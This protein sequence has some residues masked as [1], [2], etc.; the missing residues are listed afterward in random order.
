MAQHF[1]RFCTFTERLELEAVIPACTRL[2][3][4]DL[5]FAVPI[6]L[7]RDAG[8]VIIDEAWH[9]ECADEVAG[10][11]QQQIGVVP[12]QQRKPAFLHVLRIIKGSLPEQHHW[13]V[14][15]VFTEVSETLIS[16]S[17][18]RVPRDEQVLATIREVLEE[19]RREETEPLDPGPDDGGHVATAEP[20]GSRRGGAVVRDLYRGLPAARHPGGTGRAGVVGFTAGDAKRIV[21]E[22]HGKAILSQDLWQS[23]T[24]TVRFMRQHGLLEHAATQETLEM[25]RLVVPGAKRS[26]S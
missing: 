26:R 13:L 23:A 24:P 15:L 11:V 18:N 3:F 14:D 25:M 5:P 6:A 8:R 4:G 9:A 1:Y 10:R 2:R 19:H 20:G 22:T 7:S 16:G 21:D 17:L 12:C